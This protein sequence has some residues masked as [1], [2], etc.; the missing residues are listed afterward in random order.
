MYWLLSADTSSSHPAR[1]ED[2]IDHKRTSSHFNARLHCWWSKEPVI[3]MFTDQPTELW[4]SEAVEPGT[5][6]PSLQPPPAFS[7]YS[8]TPM[9]L[10]LVLSTLQ[11]EEKATKLHVFLHY[12]V[13]PE[14]NVVNQT[15]RR[16]GERGILGSHRE[17]EPKSLTRPFALQMDI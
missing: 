14:L 7:T 1:S 17:D 4:I 2:L 15:M 8:S 16:E 13:A 5:A 6:I 10:D 9:L 3:V 11:S 12:Q